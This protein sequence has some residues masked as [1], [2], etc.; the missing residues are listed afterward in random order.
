MIPPTAPGLNVSRE[1][2]DRLLALQTLVAKWNPAVNLV[3]K[4]SIADTWQRHIVDSAQIFSLAPD[5]SR[6]WADL[7]SGGGF[8]G[9]VIACLATSENPALK[10]TLVESD[11]RKAAFLSQA[12]RQL[13]L[14]VQIR[15]ERIEETAPLA[16]DVISARALAPLAKLCAYA[17][18]HLAAGGISLFHKG[19]N[20][21]AELAEAEQN[22]HF[23]LTR[24]QSITDPAAAILKIEGL[25]HAR[26]Q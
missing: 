2:E 4:A 12:A 13:R 21:A 11:R 8:P 15:A 19:A 24:I 26:P 9:L 23:R 1:T 18:R 22:W 16:A 10:V 5:A 7:G 20:V 25:S 6:H 14:N 17:H 3:S